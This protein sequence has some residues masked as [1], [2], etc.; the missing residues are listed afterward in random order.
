MH[1]ISGGYRLEAWMHAPMHAASYCVVISH[2]FGGYGGSPKWN[3]IAS[4]L[5]RAGFPTLRF[6]HRGC[7]NSE[8][9][10]ED[11]TV[12]NRIADLNAAMDAIAEE[13]GA[14]TFGL[15]GSSLGGVTA[16]MC[17]SQPRVCCTFVQAAP[18]N[19]EFF[20]SMISDLAVSSGE[21]IIV[22]GREVKQDLLHDTKQHDI[23]AAAAVAKKLFV[24]HGEND[25]LIPPSHASEIFN[26]ALHP[27]NILLVPG[28]DHPFTELKH[29]QI[30][31]EQCTAWFQKHLISCA[32]PKVE[33][34]SEE[35]E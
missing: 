26:I 4:G 21:K 16:L 27:K 17:A 33:K 14:R 3:F 9:A 10:F 8:G 7:G 28:A 6:S 34:E 25:P 15:I 1:I 13:M 12:T 5:A 30:M 32:A 22:D 20:S 11:T 31:L 2:G 24:M 23:L 18:S 19:F 29:Q 35:D